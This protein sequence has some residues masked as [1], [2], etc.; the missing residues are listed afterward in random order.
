MK[1]SELIKAITA[2]EAKGSGDPE[3]RGIRFDSRAV[4][5]GD[6]FV[7]I[8]GTRSN[9]NEFVPDALSRGAAAVAVETDMG[10][11]AVPVV[12]VAAARKALAH[13]ARAFYGNPDEEL[14]V[15]G[16][17]GTNGKTTTAHLLRAILEEWGKPT[18]LIGT[19]E[20]QILGRSVASANTTP[21]SADLFRFMRETKD[22][23]G[24]AVVMEVSS[25]S[26]ALDRV[27]G[28]SFAGATFSNLT[29][30]HLD[31]HKD[32]ENYFT[33]K[34]TLFLRHL[35]KGG[36]AAINLDDPYG[37]RLTEQIARL[38]PDVRLVTFGS[39][40]TAL[41]R[42]TTTNMSWEG[43]VMELS[44]P[45]GKIVLRSP[46][47]GTFNVSNLMSA[48][49]LALSY[50]VPAETVVAAIGRMDRV[51]GR[52]EKVREG[53]NFTVLVDYAHTP[54]ALERVLRTARSLTQ[55]RLLVVF[56]C[57][58]DRD[59]TKRPIMGRIASELADMV[60]VTS[61]NPR[62]E[63]KDAIIREILAGVVTGK[64]VLQVESDRRL[65]IGKAV[66]ASR[67][68]DCLV[69]AGKGHENYQI[70]GTQKTHFDDHEVAAECIRKKRE[71]L[72]VP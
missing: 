4:E 44:T 45:W 64:A 14:A 58:G 49:S 41:I 25:H 46:L 61:D 62:T 55:G 19:I 60:F 21:E 10:P 52:F 69:I 48:A 36:H 72:R 54:D 35:R 47:S 8:P 17:T 12:R 71:E 37:V 56:G 15:F 30:D 22:G 67:G 32:M 2:I 70:I 11:V 53:Q 57:G 33:S 9:G 34:A 28:I 42:P 31:F 66:G 40:K 16:V 3:I 29:H 1:L 63:D 39:A 50:G 38:R 59:K 20:H 26:L 5:P 24:K 6:L 23:G 18:T 51:N 65:A 7:A 27:E 13:L 43:I 68:N